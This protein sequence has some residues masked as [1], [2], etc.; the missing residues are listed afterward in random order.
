M[1]EVQLQAS[2]ECQGKLESRLKVGQLKHGRVFVREEAY[3]EDECPL[4]AVD[5]FSCEAAAGGWEMES[6]KQE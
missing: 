6:A 3:L 5:A 1:L 4:K 2:G